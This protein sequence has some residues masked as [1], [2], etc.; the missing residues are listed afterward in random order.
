V[1]C[2]NIEKNRERSTSFDGSFLISD[3]SA[4]V[5]GISIARVMTRNPQIA[6]TNGPF[7]IPTVANLII[8]G[9]QLTAIGAC[10]FMAS[11]VGSWWGLGLL[12]IAFGMVMNSVYSIIHE[13]EHAMLFDNR[14]WNDFAGSVMALFFPAPFHLIRQGHF[15]PPLRPRPHDEAFDFYFDEAHKI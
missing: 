15:G 2:R 8:I 3:L 12:A 14:F 9:L 7:R 5:S 10:F 11:Q 6:T 13:A 1:T 4:P